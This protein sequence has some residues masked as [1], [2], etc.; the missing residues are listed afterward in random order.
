[1]APAGAWN[2]PFPAHVRILRGFLH[3]DGVRIDLAAIGA[4]AAY[5][6][7]GVA[8]ATCCTRRSGSAWSSRPGGRVELESPSAS[9]PGCSD[10][11]VRVACRS[12]GAYGQIRYGDPVS[13][14]SGLVILD[15]VS[16][17][18][19]RALFELFGVYKPSERSLC[20]VSGRGAT[21]AA[22]SGGSRTERDEARRSAACQ[23][24]ELRSVSGSRC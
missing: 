15:C 10:S 20:F 14:R 5:V 7:F 2:C 8:S 17:L 22:G 3:E 13:R 24:T 18:E 9:A 16:K 21:G 1:M 11:G 6:R 19:S 4:V 23:R 12:G